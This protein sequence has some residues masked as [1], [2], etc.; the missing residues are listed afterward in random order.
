LKFA[1]KQLSALL[2]NT[3]LSVNAVLLYGP[4]QGLVREYA[5]RLSL[6]CTPNL[7]DP[8]SVTE[9]T[10]PQLKQE[11]SIL[12]DAVFSMSLAGGDC[13]II[14]HD[15]QDAIVP[16]LEYIFSKSAQAWPIIIEANALTPKS[17]LRKMFEQ[18]KNLASIPCYPQDGYDLEN[19]IQSVLTQDGLSID[20]GAKQILCASLAGDRQ[21]V[22]RE[23][24][25]LSLYCLAKQ[26]DNNKVTE[27]DAIACVGDTSEASLD[28]LV[29][30]V[31]NGNQ[32]NLDKT[33]V[34][35]YSEGFNPVTIIRYIQHHFQRLHFIHSQMAKGE[36][37]DQALGRLRPPVFFKRKANFQQQVFNW[38]LERLNR[39]LILA[40]ENEI[41]NKTSGLPAEILCN[42]TLM[43][44][45]QAAR[46]R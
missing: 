46:Q 11:P 45:A 20:R 7:N 31:G 24:E 21:I 22:R 27:I 39:A 37:L 5:Q 1:G 41:D 2:S 8:F 38:S 6:Q 18:S 16:S 33:L 15:A 23:L 10:G 29:Y 43:R 44:I 34:K 36:S 12:V 32:S 3:K 19:F 25:K 28:K 40:T 30:A 14:I 4:D 13:V 17:T 35:A 9:F 42:R 26:T